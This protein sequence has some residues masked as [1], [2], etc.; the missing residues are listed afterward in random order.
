MYVLRHVLL[1]VRYIARAFVLNLF[2]MNK[3]YSKRWV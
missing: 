1:R 3:M 2:V